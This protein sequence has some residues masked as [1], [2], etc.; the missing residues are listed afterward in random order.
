MLDFYNNGSLVG[1][2]TTANLL[3]QLG[4]AYKG[5]PRNR[6]L[7]SNEPFA[8]INFF[9]DATTTWNKIVFRNSTSSGFESDNYTTRLTT[10]DPTIDGSNVPGVAVARVT[11]TSTTT[12]TATSTGAALWGSASAVPGAPAPPMPLVIAFGI[13]VL[14]KGS[15]R[16]KKRNTAP[17][18]PDNA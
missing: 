6:M 14:A 11:G 1:E 16:P 2:F 5:N 3:T 9:G 17:T 4:P 15:K 8:F 12:L 7:D 18:S 13:A 10:Y